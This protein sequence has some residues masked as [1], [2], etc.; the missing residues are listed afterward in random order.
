MF[1]FKGGTDNIVKFS[2]LNCCVYHLKKD[3]SAFANSP[4]N[5]RQHVEVRTESYRPLHSMPSCFMASTVHS[6]WDVCNYI[7]LVVHNGNVL[8]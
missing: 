1:E 6:K 4:S 5:R 3:V 8:F 2:C 7:S